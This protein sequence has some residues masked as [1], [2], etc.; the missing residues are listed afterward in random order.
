M[1]W[2][3]LR[4]ASAQYQH[5]QNIPGQPSAAAEP[6]ILKTIASVTSDESRIGTLVKPGVLSHKASRAPR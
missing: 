6:S 1:S 2:P 5:P 3:P 4:R